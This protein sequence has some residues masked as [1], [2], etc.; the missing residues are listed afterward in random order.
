LA[1]NTINPSFIPFSKLNPIKYTT[2]IVTLNMAQDSVLVIPMKIKNTD[3]FGTML[4]FIKNS[5]E[6]R[7]HEFWSILFKSVA[8]MIQSNKT[9]WISTS[10]MSVPWANVRIDTSPKYYKL[11]VSQISTLD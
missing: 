9:L 4:K 5:S 1:Y 2:T 11:S 10:N 3:K 8:N 6:S 7:L